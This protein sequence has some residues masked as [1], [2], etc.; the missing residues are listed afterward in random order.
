MNKYSTTSRIIKLDSDKPRPDSAKDNRQQAKVQQQRAAQDLIRNQLDAIYDSKDDDLLAENLFDK[1]AGFEPSDDDQEQILS[2]LGQARPKTGLTAVPQIIRRGWFGDQTEEKLAE[3]PASS[4]AFDTLI[5]AKSQTKES[6]DSNDF[7]QNW[8]A[9]TDGVASDYEV[10]PAYQPEASEQ[11]EL[12]AQDPFR[13]RVKKPQAALGSLVAKVDWQELK[14]GLG[15][16]SERLFGAPGAKPK[17]PC[18]VQ[19][20]EVK[21]TAQE[22]EL[23]KPSEFED[24]V[25]QPSS[26]NIWQTK[27]DE[28]KANQE[29]KPWGRAKFKRLIEVPDQIKEKAQEAEKELLTDTAVPQEVQEVQPAE[30]VTSEQ[31]SAT[32]PYAQTY[33]D[34]PAASPQSGAEFDWQKYH[35]AWQEY[36]QKYY[37]YYYQ[38]SLAAQEQ[39]SQQAAVERATSEPP[40]ELADQPNFQDEALADLRSKLQQ[41]VSQSAKKVRRSRHFWPLASGALVV[42]IFLS[43]QY[44]RLII[45]NIR[46]FVAPANAMSVAVITDPTTTV[47]VSEEPR[48]IIPKINVDVPVVYGIGSDH[49]SQQAAMANGVAHFAIPGAD[50]VPGQVGNTVISGHSSNEVFD[51]G[52]YKFIFAQLDKLTDGDT[53]YANYQGK[54]YTYVVTKM[55]EV[56]PSQVD[57]LIYPTEKPVITLITC[58]PLGTAHRRLLVTAE[59]VNPSPSTASKPVQESEPAAP[60]D[61]TMPGDSPTLW[62]RI[63]G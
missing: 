25:A 22:F 35:N 31:P 24:G 59:Q 11:V 19:R 54:R 42:L 34:S 39:P 44:N 47:A 28:V 53:I 62:Q 52:E 7:M 16:L 4:P 55:E 56:M 60:S 1:A 18:P 14:T 6:S 61:A 45:A 48:L 15:G 21:P 46:A 10:A 57:K 37:E 43:L 3:L 50:A 30:S 36:Y 9:G 58:V 33:A 49:S 51:R 27:S 23:P 17:L 8:L 12:G 41:K 5:D 40:E 20:T 32:S 63:F 2:E 29:A 38:Q 26:D 13:S